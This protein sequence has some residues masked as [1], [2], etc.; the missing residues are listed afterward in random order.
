MLSTRPKQLPRGAALRHGSEHPSWKGGRHIATT[1]YILVWLPPGHPSRPTRGPYIYEHRLV[2]E[3]KLGRPLRPGEI[4]HHING[5]KTDNRP[6]NIDVLPSRAW[7]KAKHRKLSSD[8]RLPNESNPITLCACGCGSGFLKFDDRGRPRRYLP[9]HRWEL[10]TRVCPTCG[11]T[12]SPY[13]GKQRFCS[14]PCSSIYRV[15]VRRERA[16]SKM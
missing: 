13:Y 12:Y 15:K 3:Q 1:G 6:E 5:I 2:A 14:N 9:G 7:H 4:P 8:L 11:S 16:M 10:K